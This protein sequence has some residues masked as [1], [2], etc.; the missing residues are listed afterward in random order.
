[1]ASDECLAGRLPIDQAQCD[2]QAGWRN[3][4]LSEF[5]KPPNICFNHLTRDLFFY[6]DP[7]MLLIFFRAGIAAASTSHVQYFDGDDRRDKYDDFYEQLVR[8][9]N[10]GVFPFAN[11]LRTSWC[12]I[13]ARTLTSLVPQR[14]MKITGLVS[15]GATPWSSIAR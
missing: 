4:S 1:M 2:H 5:D 15:M 7:D 13:S 3:F 12:R 8:V 6:W 10:I 9:K 11:T 14:G